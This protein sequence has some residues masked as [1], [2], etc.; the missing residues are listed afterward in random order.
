MQGWTPLEAGNVLHNDQ[1]GALPKSHRASVCIR[2]SARCSCAVRSA[3]ELTSCMLLA[4]IPLTLSSCC[5]NL[6]SCSG[7]RVNS[8]HLLQGALPVPLSSHTMTS[9]TCN[10]RKRLVGPSIHSQGLPTTVT[11]TLPLLLGSAAGSSAAV[12]ASGQHTA[13]TAHACSDGHT[14]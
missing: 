11:S 5:K 1:K 9:G 10:M 2:H 12:A 3:M 7:L 6:V 13:G 4:H 8:T 14:M